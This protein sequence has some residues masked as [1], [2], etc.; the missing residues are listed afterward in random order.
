MM[1]WPVHNCQL[2]VL[3]PGPL[4]M[5]DA[6]LLPTPHGRRICRGEGRPPL[7]ILLGKPSG[8]AMWTVQEQDQV[9]VSK[10]H[11]TEFPSR[12]LRMQGL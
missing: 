10:C 12:V 4:Q 5:C 11:W 3:L 7:R 6:Q 9:R 1:Q 8:S 2:K